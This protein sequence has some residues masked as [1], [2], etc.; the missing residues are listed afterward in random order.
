MG[1]KIIKPVFEAKTSIAL[2]PS[3]T[4]FFYEL[5]QSVPEETVVKIDAAKFLDDTGA[6]VQS[7]PELEL[8]NSYI[9]VY[10]NG[11]VQMEDNFAYTAGENGVGNL[12]IT[13]PEG[14]TIAKGTPIII[15]VANFDPVLAADADSDEKE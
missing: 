2:S 4:R 5:E 11:V 8:N 9:N 3:V 10:I 1:L 15:E 12:L 14:S 6:A 7:F 13:V